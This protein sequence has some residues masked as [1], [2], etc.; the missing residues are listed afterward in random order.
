MNLARP[1][2]LL[3]VVASVLMGAFLGSGLYTFVS[4]QGL[5][6][7]SDDP[8]ICVNCHIMRPEFDDWRHGSHHAVAVCND[9]HLP[10]DNLAHKL[11]VKASNGYHHSRAFTFQDF[12][13]P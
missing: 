9:C 13:E 4:A 11:F 5:S 1:L 6:Y 12:K 8:A 2:V 3:S 10:H 7:M